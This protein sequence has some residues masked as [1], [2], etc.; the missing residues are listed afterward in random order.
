MS[1]EYDGLLGVHGHGIDLR[2][3]GGI[4]HEF[5]GHRREAQSRGGERVVGHRGRGRRDKRQPRHAARHGDIEHRRRRDARLRRIG[6]RDEHGRRTDRVEA[7]GLEV[8]VAHIHA[9]AEQGLEAPL[10]Q[11]ALQ[12][13][14][15]IGAQLVN[16]DSHHEPWPCGSLLCRRAERDQTCQ[17]RGCKPLHSYVCYTSYYN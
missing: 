4:D 15:V 7:R 13:F 12:Q 1:G 16:D 8:D 2:G 3:S 17:H 5:V 14:Y 9:V 6:A 10:A 11:I